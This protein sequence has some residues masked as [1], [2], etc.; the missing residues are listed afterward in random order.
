MPT[1]PSVTAYKATRIE[2]I[3]DLSHAEFAGALEALLGRIDL[4]ALD[5]LARQSPDAARAKLSSFV[6]PL[7]FTLFQKIDHGGL[8][9]ALAGKPVRATTYV[10]GNA[11]IAVEMTKHDPRA[12]LYVPLRLFVQQIGERRVLI[13]Y[14]LPSATMAQFVS[15]A[16]DAVART[17]DAKA[18][19][20]LDE[21]VKRAH[22]ASEVRPLST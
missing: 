9:T 15:P 11:L 21:T 12:G 7:D 13:T 18:Q 1:P 10:F 20:L 2:I 22:A 3:V 19:R 4:D 6:G 8:L 16:I 14:E 17:L 5:D